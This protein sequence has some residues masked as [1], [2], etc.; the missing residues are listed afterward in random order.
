[1][2]KVGCEGDAPDINL[3]AHAYRARPRPTP[4]VAG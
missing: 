3:I 4:R 2:A 1:M